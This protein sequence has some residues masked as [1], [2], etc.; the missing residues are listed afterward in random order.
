MT[1]GRGREGGRERGGVG[2][3]DYD[4]KVAC[5]AH[6]LLNVTMSRRGGPSGEL[7]ADEASRIGKVN[8]TDRVRG[9]VA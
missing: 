4:A 3:P 2:G 7:A 8:I 9:A 1:P 5:D 6:S